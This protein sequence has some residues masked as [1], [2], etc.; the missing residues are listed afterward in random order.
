VI[1]RKINLNLVPNLAKPRDV[2]RHL[3]CERLIMR[4]NN[5]IDKLLGDAIISSILIDCDNKKIHLLSK[6][7][8]N[9]TLLKYTKVEFKGIEYQR[10]DKIMIGN[11]FYSV[12]LFED[13][14]DFEK[15]QSKH[16]TQMRM[17]VGDEITQRII[18]DN[19]INIYKLETGV[20]MTAIIACREVTISRRTVYNNLLEFNEW[21]ARMVRNKFYYWKL[22]P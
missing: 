9:S 14:L 17:D 18:N 20:G 6:Y 13:G 2:V 19:E 7:Y 10:L 12:E 3:S 15:E 8:I 4:D 22:K 5:E 1:N 21:L 16:F 11:V